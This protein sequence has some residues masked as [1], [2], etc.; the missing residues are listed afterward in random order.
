[1]QKNQAALSMAMATAVLGLAAHTDALATV[2]ADL[3]YQSYNARAERGKSLFAALSAATPFHENG[4]VFIGHTSREIRWRLHWRDT[5]GGNCRIDDV[6]VTLHT[7]IVL[8]QLGGVDPDRQAEYTRFYTAL[9]I[10]EN[11]HYQIEQK[12][13]AA[14]ER[15]LAALPEASCAGIE[16]VANAKGNDIVREF[17]RKEVQYDAETDHGRTQGAVLK[18]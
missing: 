18:N 16:A 9:R 6:R 3:E 5:G 12:M 10:H 8:P 4:R 14:L 2:Q 17:D 11:G 1:M 15:E 7:T 13:A